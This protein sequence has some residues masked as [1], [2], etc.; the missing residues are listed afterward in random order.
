VS[1]S[2]DTLTLT[3]NGAPDTTFIVKVSGDKITRIEGTITPD[4]GDPPIVGPIDMIQESGYQNYKPYE[5]PEAE[6]PTDKDG[7]P[8]TTPVYNFTGFT[9]VSSPNRAQT[10]GAQ[11]P[12]VGWEAVPGADVLAKLKTAHGYQFWVRLNSSTANNWSFLTAVVTDFAPDKGYE[13][14][15]WFGNQPGASQ[16]SLTDNFTE[17]LAVGTWYQIRVIMNSTGFNM[18]EDKWLYQWPPNPDPKKPFNQS[19]AEK[20][21]W[22]IPLQHQVGAGVTERSGGAYDITNGDYSFNLDFYGFEL[23]SDAAGTPMPMT[24]L[25]NWTWATSDDSRINGTTTFEP[26]GASRITNAVPVE[27]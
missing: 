13:Y 22:Q 16:G 24:G 7:N 15:H 17:N 3:P 8:I 27:E 10:S 9:K 21:Q 2:G 6:R 25:E 5:Y 11:F 12:L 26:G 23:I 14:K 18:D 1:K 4:N 20:V 19:A